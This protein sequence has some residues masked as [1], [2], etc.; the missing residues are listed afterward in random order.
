MQV[1]QTLT[2]V[3]G[4]GF[5]R[6][7]I[8]WAADAARAGLAAP[9]T[10]FL[11][12]SAQALDGFPYA[13]EWRGGI[14]GYVPRDGERLLLA[15]GEPADKRRIVAL[16]RERGARFASLV[17]PTAVVAGSAQLGEGVIVCPLALVSADA[18][19]DEFVTVNAMSS[20]GH[21]VHVGA[22][23]TLSAHVD[24][25]GRVEVGEGCFFGSGARVLPRVR[26]GERARIGAGAVVM[27][28]V[29]AEA[30]MYAPPAKAL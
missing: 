23:A 14:Q 7:L 18:R 24:L 17:H 25:T 8:N 22:Y 26:I 13:L 29:K 20:V 3:G 12:D 9:L 28:H 1:T 5:G 10:G 30:V 11:D 15:L 19:L 2:L 6:E 27:R 21:D 16:L 4:G